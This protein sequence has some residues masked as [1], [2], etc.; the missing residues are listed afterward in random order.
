MEKKKKRKKNKSYQ[1]DGR[2][3]K[4]TRQRSSL[5]DCHVAKC[6]VTLKFVR[7]EKTQSLQAKCRL[8][9]KKKGKDKNKKF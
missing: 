6:I 3:K 1:G 2:L 8:K 9:T 7:V 5:L 4:F